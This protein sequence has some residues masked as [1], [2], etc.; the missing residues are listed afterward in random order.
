MNTNHNPT[1]AAFM[2]SE[3]DFE[4]ISDVSAEGWL[5]S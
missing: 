5:I 1:F 4:G 2:H 3:Y